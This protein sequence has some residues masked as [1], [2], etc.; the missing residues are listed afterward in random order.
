MLQGLQTVFRSV[1]FGGQREAKFVDL[2][3][4]KGGD[5]DPQDWL[6]RYCNA[7]EANSISDRRRLTLIPS[8][9]KGSALTWY[10]KAKYEK[11][12]RYWNNNED[13]E[14][15][16]R[17]FVYQFV[18]HYNTTHRR[19]QW[20]SALRRCK[21]RPGQS[22]E[23]YAAEM[24]SLYL[25][26]DPSHNTPEDEK[27]E[28]FLQGLRSEFQ[29]AI[30]AAA[31]RDVEEAI[32]RARSI[33]AV[34]SK[35]TT[36][37]GYSLSKAY[38]NQSVEFIE[39]NP[40][41]M[42]QLIEKNNEK[43]FKEFKQLLAGTN[44]TPQNNNSGYN[45]NNSHNSNRPANNNNWRNNNSTNNWQSNSVNNNRPVMRNC[46]NCGRT[47]HLARDCKQPRMNQGGEQN[48]TGCFNCKQPGHIA[49]N[50][51]TPPRGPCPH[52]N[53]VGHWARLCPTRMNNNGQRAA[54]SQFTPVTPFDTI[55]PT[56]FPPPQPV[57]SSSRPPVTPPRPHLN[58]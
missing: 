44:T 21:Q 45:N 7:C 32:D 48:N 54:L 23:E 16:H 29:T 41:N 30:A 40:I 15:K 35:D 38:L 4:F 26:L 3:A 24:E 19:T 58:Y 13:R 55:T 17:S 47:G 1:G 53:Q 22:V 42:Q 33:E 25:K 14:R 10:N 6:D 39:E 31:P 52:C 8:F 11:D 57:P 20:R 2:P 43:L 5:Q 36:L 50:C 34:L 18:K 56:Y 46:Y 51:R 37:S 12:I 49:R 27:I 28:Q 9:L